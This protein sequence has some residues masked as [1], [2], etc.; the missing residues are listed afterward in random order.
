MK[1]PL[2]I[3]VKMGVTERIALPR[4]TIT[5]MEW[6]DREA[7]RMRAHGIECV[8]RNVKGLCWLSR[9]RE[10]CAVVAGEE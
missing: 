9:P 4:E 7:A 10:G 1:N 5:C 8:A 2:R 6:C 3:T